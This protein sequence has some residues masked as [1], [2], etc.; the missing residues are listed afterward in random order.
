MTVEELRERAFE[1]RFGGVRESLQRIKMMLSERLVATN[2][3][4]ASFYEKRKKYLRESVSD[5]IL[6]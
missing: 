1:R 6:K 4:I 2:I 5:D 3:V